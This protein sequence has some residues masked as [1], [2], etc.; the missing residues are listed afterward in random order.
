MDA[1]FIV[2]ENAVKTEYSSLPKETVDITKGFVIDTIGTIM[3]GSTAYGVKELKEQLLDWGGKQESTILFHGEKLPAPSA[4][5]VNSLMAHARE[6]DDV[7]D[8]AHVHSNI[9]ILPAVLAIS[10]A[11]G[12]VSGKDFITAMA[13]GTDL[14]CRMGVAT[15]KDTGWHW[16]TVYG[17]AG[18]ALAAGKILK[19]DEK[20]MHNALGIAY[21]MTSGILQN[22]IDGALMKRIMPGLSAK[23]GVMAACLATKGITGA[24]GLWEGKYGYFNLY[25]RGFYSREELIKDLGK[26][27]EGTNSSVKLYPCCRCNHASIDAMLSIQKTKDIKAGD[28]K[29]IEVIIPKHISEITGKPFEIRSNPQVDAQFSLQYTVAASLIRKKISLEDFEEVAVRDPQV[30]DLTKKIKIVVDPSL[31]ERSLTPSTVKIELKNGEKVTYKTEF[32]K[33]Q[34]QNRLNRDDFFQ[35]L[36][37]LLSYSNMPV[38]EKKLEEIFTM[39][40]NLEELDDMRKLTGLL[41]PGKP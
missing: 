9:T 23:G 16:S 40:E 34:P 17:Y 35:K 28:V 20:Q 8:D 2:V 6:L 41:A 11:K 21:T 26:R 30:M 22:L 12:N 27:F 18:C 39:L 14:V 3:A 7:H 4:A 38:T 5:F 29:E 13:L 37:G 24:K 36:H 1:S 19:L 32:M 25:E 31:P 10:E 15:Q 33:G